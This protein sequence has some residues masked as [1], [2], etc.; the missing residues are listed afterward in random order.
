M[1]LREGLPFNLIYPRTPVAVLLE[2]PDLHSGAINWMTQTCS[3]SVGVRLVSV[4]TEEQN[5]I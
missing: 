1:F 3:E 2:Q 5:S 4:W